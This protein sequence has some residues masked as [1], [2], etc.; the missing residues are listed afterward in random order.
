M[1][2]AASVGIITSFPV[3]RNNPVG[4]THALQGYFVFNID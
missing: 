3:E 4:R 1:D 2:G